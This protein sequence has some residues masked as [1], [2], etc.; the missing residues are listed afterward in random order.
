MWITAVGFLLVC[1]YI[2]D[3][4]NYD[5]APKQ[6]RERLAEPQDHWQFK[7]LKN[8]AFLAVILGAVFINRPLFLR[9]ALMLGAAIGSYFT[10]QKEIHRRNH[11]K[12]HPIREVGILFVGIF[13]TMIPALDWLQMNAGKIPSPSPAF[14]FW[15]SGLLSSVLDNAPTY[16]S[17]LSA[18]FGLFI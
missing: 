8:L 4:G 7:G 14:F 2:L 1:F 13:A 6:I 16:L 11:F 12:F 5:R 9:E 17:F 15:A 3:T 10:P 18:T